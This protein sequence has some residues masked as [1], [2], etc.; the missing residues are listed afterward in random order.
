ML[1][2]SQGVDHGK[3]GVVCEIDDV[4]LGEGADDH[5]VTHSAEHAGGV[6]DGFAAAELDVV[7]GEE[8]RK[9]AE[10]ADAD[11][12][13]HAGAG[14]GFA[15]NHRPS[16]SGEWLGRVL[17]ALG[18]E[19]L[20]VGDEAGNFS[21]AEF[22]NGKEVFH[23]KLRGKDSVAVCVKHTVDGGQGFVDFGVCDIERREQTEGFRAGW[24]NDQA[25]R[26]QGFD[27]REGGS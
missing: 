26:H 15:K 14:G 7:G 12:E 16:L 18:F 19:A 17:S 8:H 9:S 22:F 6:F 20:S 27:D 23:L 3:V 13:R 24:R 4:L 5:A 10:F 2:I 21:S 25:F 1:V 11:L